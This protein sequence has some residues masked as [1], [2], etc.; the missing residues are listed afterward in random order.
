MALREALCHLCLY[1]TPYPYVKSTAL[2]LLS[3]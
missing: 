1:D 2:R 3:A